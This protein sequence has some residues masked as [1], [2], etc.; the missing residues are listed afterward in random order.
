MEESTKIICMKCKMSLMWTFVKESRQ[1]KNNHVRQQV[2][3]K[4]PKHKEC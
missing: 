2:A 4:Y 1:Q 3:A